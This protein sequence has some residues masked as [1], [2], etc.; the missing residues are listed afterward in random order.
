MKKMIT[1]PAIMKVM[2]FGSKIRKDKKRN[3]EEQDSKDN[4]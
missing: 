1:I 2:I 3:E 4:L